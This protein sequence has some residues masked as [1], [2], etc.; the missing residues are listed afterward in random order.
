MSQFEIFS[1]NVPLSKN[2][3]LMS[4][5]RVVQT[6]LILAGVTVL[7][8]LVVKLPV[9]LNSISAALLTTVEVTVPIPGILICSS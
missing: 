8:P 4:V 7:P 9:S 1:L 2:K 5:T 6:Q 3:E